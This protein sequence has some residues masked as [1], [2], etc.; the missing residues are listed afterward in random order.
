MSQHLP[1]AFK[2]PKDKVR[3]S[4]C[5]VLSNIHFSL[6]S[7][8]NKDIRELFFREMLLTCSQAKSPK[9]QMAGCIGLGRLAS[10][11]NPRS[12]PRAALEI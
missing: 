5:G 12:P 4:V 3:A 1:R 10:V 8:L 11:A 6:W 7:R 9:V 2:D